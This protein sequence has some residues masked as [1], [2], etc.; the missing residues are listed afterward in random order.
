MKFNC[1]PTFI[2]WGPPTYCH[3]G[4]T[5]HLAK[6][7]FNGAWICDAARSWAC[8]QEQV[9]NAAR[10]TLMN[11]VNTNQKIRCWHCWWKKSCT[12]WYVVYPIIY[13]VLYISTVWRGCQTWTY[14]FGG[15]KYCDQMDP[16]NIEQTTWKTWTLMIVWIVLLMVQKSGYPVEVGSLS[17]YLR[18]VSYIP[19][20]AGFLPST[21]VQ[22]KQTRASKSAGS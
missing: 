9:S 15:W 10:L 16:M 21:V 6:D 22:I 18:R 2:I 11:L 7:A 19:G 1:L 12:S 4:S 5:A 3:C 17:H 14:E 8:V 20:G 13:R